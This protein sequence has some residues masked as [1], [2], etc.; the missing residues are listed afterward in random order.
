MKPQLLQEFEQNKGRT[1][2]GIEGVSAPTA[3]FD[4][5]GEY[6]VQQA[7]MENSAAQHGVKA[8]DEVATDVQ[9]QRRHAETGVSRDRNSV[10]S[11]GESSGKEYRNL[12]NEHDQGKKAFDD[13]QKAEN[14]RQKFYKN[15]IA[16]S[17]DED[18]EQIKDDMSNRFN[19][20]K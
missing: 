2:E 1:G 20:K 10:I 15:D 4:L 6:R 7:D 8:G 9:N 12:Q 3:A 19:G 18:I 13:A 17:H 5:K 11:S 14:E 16:I